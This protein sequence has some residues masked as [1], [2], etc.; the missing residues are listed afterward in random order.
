MAQMM[1]GS[2]LKTLVRSGTRVT[3]EPRLLV[4]NLDLPST[5]AFG[6]DLKGVSFGVAAGEIFGIAGVAGNG[7]NELARALAGELVLATPSAIILDG[8]QI[9]HLGAEERR[10]H[11]L[12][13]V[14][15]ERTGHATVPEMSLSD[16]TLL[17]ARNR[18]GLAHYG[19]VRRNAAR[20]YARRVIEEFAVKAGGPDSNAM[21]LSGGNLQKFVVG[22]EVLQNPEVLI[23]AQPTWG[24]DAGAAVA[25][26]QALFRLAQNGTAIVVISQDLDELLV[27]TDRLAVINVGTLS[28][29][30]STAEASIDE[31]GLLMGGLHGLEAEADAPRPGVTHVG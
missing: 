6:T 8:K 5:E 26:H 24:V 16:N 19:F 3:A 21:T 15:E 27:I 20:A 25:I 1:I 2:E 17:S 22:R 10:M 18:M 30:L 28:P 23:I 14:P 9:G 12:C 29:A 31:I 11:G 13:S 4:S 7:Q